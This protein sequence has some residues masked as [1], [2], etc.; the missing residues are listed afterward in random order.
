MEDTGPYL[1][2]LRQLYGAAAVTQAQAHIMQTD[3][4]MGIP[5]PGLL[6]DGCEMHNKLLVAYDKVHARAA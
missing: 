5:A 6:L 1:D 2:A 4:F 3:R